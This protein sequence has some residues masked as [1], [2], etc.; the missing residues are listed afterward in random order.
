MAVEVLKVKRENGRVME[1]VIGIG[2]IEERY[3]RLN[4]EW[5]SD[6]NGKPVLVSRKR[7]GVQVA[8]RETYHIPHTDYQ[9]REDMIKG[10]FGEDRSKQDTKK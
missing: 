10:I 4:E 3:S 7:F 6:K 5:E 9:K 2:D 8:D 1:L